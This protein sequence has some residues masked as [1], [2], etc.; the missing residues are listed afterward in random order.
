MASTILLPPGVLTSTSKKR[1]CG[2]L[3]ASQ[4]SLWPTSMQ[5]RHRG[6]DNLMTIA[7]PSSLAAMSSRSNA[8]RSGSEMTIGSRGS[9][10]ATAGEA[11]R[12]ATVGD[13]YTPARNEQQGTFGAN[14]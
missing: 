13:V 3:R 6:R 12:G 2:F 9:N 8:L 5:A 1:W 7:T 10:L 11:S 14:W 4:S